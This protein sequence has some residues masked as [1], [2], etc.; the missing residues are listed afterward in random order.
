MLLGNW[1]ALVSEN[2]SLVRR[3][4]SILSV[5]SSTCT[6]RGIIPITTITTLPNQPRATRVAARV[7][8][9]FHVQHA[10]SVVV[11][12]FK[13]GVQVFPL[14]KHVLQPRRKVYHRN[15]RSVR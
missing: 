1:T 7:S 5:A 9:Y 8:Q 14:R 11:E 4:S 15:G 10:I 3:N 12:L 13:W 2:K 6:T